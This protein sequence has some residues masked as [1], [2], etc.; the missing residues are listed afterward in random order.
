MKY[1]ESQAE[2]IKIKNEIEKGKYIN[3]DEIKEGTDNLNLIL[4]DSLENLKNKIIEDLSYLID[5]EPLKALDKTLALENKEHLKQLKLMQS[6]ILN[7]K[8]I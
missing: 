3:I 2:N 4:N 7:N 6:K 5:K 8:D 1:K